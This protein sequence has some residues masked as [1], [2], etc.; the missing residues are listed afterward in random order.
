M[1]DTN[2]LLADKRAQAAEA[3]KARENFK[4]FFQNRFLRL[5]IG[6]VILVA[7][8]YFGYQFSSFF[9]AERAEG[10]GSWLFYAV[11]VG[12]TLLLAARFL[13]KFKA[14]E[15]LPGALTALGILV[16]VLAFAFSGFG[17]TAKRMLVNAER[18]VEFNDCLPRAGDYAVIQ[19][20][21][22]DLPRGGHL[23]FYVVGKAQIHNN[24]IGYCIDIAKD[25]NGQELFE[26]YYENGGRIATIIPRFGEK[27]LASVTSLP[28]EECMFQ[29]P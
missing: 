24:A 12:G 1:A 16:L 19:G 13:P 22:V 21:Q 5:F 10:D 23:N 3:T 15:W 9:R 6:A 27:V 14:A 18:C 8:I 26:L 17:N 2:P 11:L 29:Y 28:A 7:V 25:N 4:K 20:G